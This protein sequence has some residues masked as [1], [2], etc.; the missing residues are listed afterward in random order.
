M[1]FKHGFIGGVI[2]SDGH[3]YYNRR[4]TKHFGAL[5]KMAN[6]KF[7]D[8]LTEI[9]NTLGIQA[10]TYTAKRSKQSYSDKPQHVIYIPTKE[11]GRISHRF[12]T[13]K[14]KRFSRL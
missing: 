14:L 3:V 9:L 11:L 4:K 1:A 12:L 7:K 8:Q 10:T 5:I 13:I 6:S 2:D